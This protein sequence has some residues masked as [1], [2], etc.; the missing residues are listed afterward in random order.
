[1][2]HSIGIY[3]K[4]NRVSLSNFYGEGPPEV[5]GELTLDGS[6]QKVSEQAD[7]P[8]EAMPMIH[9]LERK[10]DFLLSK[11]KEIDI[12]INGYNNTKTELDQ[13]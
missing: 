4:H 2:I 1:M 9:K 3:Q 13:K 11:V 6:K 8:K 12:V 10:Y 5:I 7:L